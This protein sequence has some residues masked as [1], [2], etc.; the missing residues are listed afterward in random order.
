MGAVETRDLTCLCEKP[1]PLPPDKPLVLCKWADKHSAQVGEV[2]T[3]FL[4]YTNHGGQPM[5]DI[6]VS[7]SL[8]GRLEYVAGSAQSDRPAV[9]TTQENEVGSVVLRWEVSGRLLPGHS[10]VV[11]FQVRIR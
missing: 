10:G 9:F 5:T 3:I 2:V 1:E 4:K 8:N 6:A 7:D 11:R